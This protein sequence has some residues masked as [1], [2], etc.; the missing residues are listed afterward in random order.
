MSFLLTVVVS[1]AALIISLV[2]HEFMHGFVAYLLGDRTA[3]R[4]GRLTLNPLAHIDPIG[5]VLL[6]LLAIVTGFPIIGWAKPV[7]YNP[8]NLRNQKWGPIMVGLAGPFA[9]FMLALIFLTSLRF[10]TFSFNLSSEN[11][12]VMFFTLLAEINIVLGIFNLIPV[13]PL[14]GSHLLDS[15][16]DKPQYRELRFTLQTRGPQILMILVFLDFL[17]GSHVFG[18]IFTGAVNWA[19]GLFGL[20]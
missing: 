12:V 14:D 16:L 1:Y 4:M 2:V 7:P 5:T 9:N 18:T 11:L 19:F 15:M 3:E 8:Y 17:T 6:P 13:P 20:A 10:M